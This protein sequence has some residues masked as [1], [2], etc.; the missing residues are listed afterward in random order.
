MKTKLVKQCFFVAVI[1]ISTATTGQSSEED[2]DFYL[3]A[4]AVNVF[5]GLDGLIGTGDDQI[6]PNPSPV[7]G[8][9]RNEK[10]SFSYVAFDFGSGQTDAPSLPTG[11]NAITFLN[12]SALINPD[13]FT[14]NG[15]IFSSLDV[16]G[17]EPF[18][19][20]GT[21]SAQI[22]RQG[23][24]SYDPATGAFTLNI[25]FTANLVTGSANGVN[26][27][28]AGEAWLVKAS[29]FD[30]FN[31]NVYVHDVL[32]PKARAVGASKLAFFDAT[33]TVPTSSGGSG[34]GFPSMPVRIVAFGVNINGKWLV[35]DFDGDQ[36]TDL[37]WRKQSTGQNR[38]WLMNGPV[39]EM[40]GSIP[41]IGSDWVVAG[42]GDFDGDGKVDIYWR[43]TVTGINRIWFMDGLTRTGFE[44]TLRMI[45]QN[46]IVAAV[47]DL[48]NDSKADIVWRNMMLPQTRAWIMDGATQTDRAAL[49]LTANTWHIVGCG[50][51]NND[52]NDDLLWRNGSN[53]QNRVWL[54]KGPMRQSSG[55][56]N[57][58]NTAFRVGG[59]GD[60]T[61]D[62][63]AD[64][65]FH[66]DANG[67]SRLWEIDG[68]NRLSARQLPLQNTALRGTA[69]GDFNGDSN[70]DI[71]WRNNTN[72]RNQIWN[73]NGP[74]RTSI[75][76]V[77]VMPIDFS[78]VP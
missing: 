11:F 3:D 34:G 52:G 5:P 55:A 44:R 68:L 25:D 67:Q 72:G 1:G 70:L 6:S 53:G 7:N 9:G 14:M 76:G 54:M 37:P 60:F 65:L 45:D 8:S 2:F 30:T 46:W 20:H 71:F 63:R 74:I 62:G 28:I 15:P 10:G 61:D 43:N 19:G 13:A 50:D 42:T 41:S 16:G 23:E 48:N 57:I 17:T 24:F 38:L 75:N 35:N 66:N 4:T 12:G 32:I 40:A 73:M 26:F 31:A 77:V 58:M 64:I 39:R 49:P 59:V 69:I 47:C 36:H 33:G 18:P 56:I 78:P 22:T 29:D 21:F 27:D 51:F